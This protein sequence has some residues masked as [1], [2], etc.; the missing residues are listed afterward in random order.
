[1]AAGDA[2]TD[3]PA[4]NQAEH[5]TLGMLRRTGVLSRIY[6]SGC[7]LRIAA[8]LVVPAL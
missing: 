5:A 3:P 2:P 6:T 1:M 4:R 8:M 7:R